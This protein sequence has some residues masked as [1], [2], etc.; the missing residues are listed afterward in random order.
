MDNHQP[1]HHYPSPTIKHAYTDMKT[2]PETF[3]LSNPSNRS[4][5]L[6]KQVMKPEIQEDDPNSEDVPD[7]DY[8]QYIRE[9]H[10]QY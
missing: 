2:E 3:N 4:R 1:S 8:I 7:E 6:T 10:P 9:M 5:N